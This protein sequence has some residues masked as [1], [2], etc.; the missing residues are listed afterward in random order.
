[1]HLSIHIE[2]T[3]GTSLL[4]ELQKFYGIDRIMVYSADRDKIIRMNHII[5]SPANESLT[6]IKAFLEHTKIIAFIYQLYAS[7]LKKSDDVLP[8]HD[9]EDVPDNVDAIQGHFTPDRFAKLLP[10]S[11]VSV[12]LRDPLERIISQYLHW[13]RAGGNMGFRVEVPYNPKMTFEEYA[14]RDEFTNFQTRAL[15][16]MKLEDFDLVGITPRLNNFV[17]RI[18]GKSDEK[19]FHAT[20]MNYIGQKPKYEDLGITP[21]TIERFKRIND[22]DY[23]TYQKAIELAA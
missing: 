7:F 8:W 9:P 1:M 12:V 20:Q 3:G 22:E 14:F 17:A 11:F 16:S 15:G 19:D 4:A 21:E 6:K 13:R 5:I 23:K 2:R 10:T 18:I